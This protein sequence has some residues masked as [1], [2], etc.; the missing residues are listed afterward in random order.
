MT[1]ITREG[2]RSCR[3]PRDVDELEQVDMVSLKAQWMWPSGP[4]TLSKDL[5]TDLLVPCI[6]LASASSRPQRLPQLG[7]ALRL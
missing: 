6:W 4:G 1:K 5:Q 2:C 7:I 3:I